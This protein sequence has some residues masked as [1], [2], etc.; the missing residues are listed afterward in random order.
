MDTFTDSYIL[1]ILPKLD[2][3]EEA[4]GGFPQAL[5]CI[6]IWSLDLPGATQAPEPD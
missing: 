6:Q 5:G 4:A 3:K 1:G 2:K